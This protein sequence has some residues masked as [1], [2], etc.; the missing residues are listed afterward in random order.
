MPEKREDTREDERGKGWSC[1][2]CN[3]AHTYLLPAQDGKLFVLKLALRQHPSVSD[4]KGFDSRPGISLPLML[5]RKVKR[6]YFRGK[7]RT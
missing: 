6:K 7:E 5:V 3:P 1:S 4:T 2:S